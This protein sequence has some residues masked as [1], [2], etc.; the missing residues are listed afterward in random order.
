MKKYLIP[1]LVICAL[2]A[3]AQTTP[4]KALIDSRGTL[5]QLPVGCSLGQLF[6]ATDA[7]AGANVYGCTTPGN[8]GVWTIQGGSGSGTVTA[9][10]GQAPITSSG[11]TAPQV[12][13]LGCVADVDA[14]ST[15]AVPIAGSAAATTAAINAC[16]AA[17]TSSHIYFPTG[18]YNVDNSAN[19]PGISS[20]TFSG[21]LDF[22][23]GALIKFNTISTASGDVLDLENGTNLT[24]RNIHITGPTTTPQSRSNAA[25]ALSNLGLHL[26]NQTNAYIDGA[27]VDVSGGVCITVELSVHTNLSNINMANCS[28][29]GLFIKSADFTTLTNFQSNV[30]FDNPIELTNYTVDTAHV[31]TFTGSNIVINNS[32]ALGIAVPGASHVTIDGFVVNGTCSAGIGVFTD[33]SV[34]TAMPTD[35]HFSHGTITGAGTYTN[36]ISPCTS[37][38]GQ[39]MNADTFGYASFSDITVTG[40]TLLAAFIHIGTNAVLNNITAYSNVGGVVLQSVTAVQSTNVLL[41]GGTGNYFATGVTTLTIDGYTAHNLNPSNGL[42]RALDLESNG[43]VSASNINIEDTQATPTGYIF[44]GIGSTNVSPVSNLQFNVPHGSGTTSVDGTFNV[45][46]AGATTAL[47]ATQVGY[48]NSGSTSITSDSG[49]K[50]L[51]A[52]TTSSAPV[53]VTKSGTTGSSTCGYALTGFNNI[54]WTPLS[55]YVSVT[56]CNIAGINNAI[57]LPSDAGILSYCLYVQATGIGIPGLIACQLVPGSTYHDTTYSGQAVAFPT[58]N[59][60]TTT[61]Q[62]TNGGVSGT[63]GYIGNI[64]GVIPPSLASS[65]EQAPG[66]ILEIDNVSDGVNFNN[67]LFIQNVLSGVPSVAFGI[68]TVMYT[69]EPTG[70]SNTNIFGVAGSAVWDGP[71]QAGNVSSANNQTIIKQ[72]NVGVATGALNVAVIQGGT[73]GNVYG[74]DSGITML[75]GTATNIIGQLSV[76]EIDASAAGSVTGYITAGEF[77]INPNPGVTPNSYNIYINNTGFSGAGTTV[78]E[79][80]R[81]ENGA[82]SGTGSLGIHVADP[83]LDNL[84]EGTLHAGPRT[85]FTT[86]IQTELGLSSNA[87]TLLNNASHPNTLRVVN[88]ENGSN[89]NA[90]PLSS[91]QSCSGTMNACN[92]IEGTLDVTGGTTTA[93]TG[94]GEQV[95]VSGGVVSAAYGFLHYPMTITGGTVTLGYG[96]LFSA[97]AI[98][99]G[100]VLTAYVPFEANGRPAGSDTSFIVD[101]NLNVAPTSRTTAGITNSFKN[102][103]EGATF[104]TVAHNADWGSLV[105]PT[106]NAG[107]STWHLQSRIDSATF[108][109]RLTVSDT[110]DTSTPG[111]LISGLGGS[112]AGDLE[113]S[114]GTAPTPGASVFGWVAPTAMTTSVLLQSPNAVPAANQVMLF[115]APAS[116]IAA[117]TWVSIPVTRG[118]SDL[119]A[120]TA[121]LTSSALFT[122]STTGMYRVTYYAKITTPGTSS[123]LGG[124]TGFVLNYTD[125]TDSVAQNLTLTEAN[126][127]GTILSI[128]TGNVTNTTAAVIYGTATVFAK[129]GVAMTYNLGYSSTGTVMQYEVHVKAE[130]L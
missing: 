105:I 129:T 8:P 70:S 36:A 87:V 7:I 76:V 83:A 12:R 71:G 2:G 69:T 25:A 54:G 88:Q 67:T 17:H 94:S 114:A 91:H 50:R 14:V 9:V 13:C 130:A 19:Q 100:G 39:G 110:G 123:I 77:D 103:V 44:L 104:D 72:G 79:G 24:I 65:V 11:G 26:K 18:V 95:N 106:S 68:S 93:G 64:Q 57:V 63:H 60:N 61:G 66:N 85:G 62:L 82:V 97:P 3:V 99:G 59:A 108:T 32:T 28:S 98:S 75:N 119:T 23:P 47:P 120:Q 27:Q 73:L 89:A 33:S 30:T 74:T 42:H 5:A 109:D 45:I 16:L 122:P 101:S 1:L 92:G 53:S 58:P 15:C 41:S 56:N 118:A 84:F 125:G 55:S 40:S 6:F 96:A 37:P 116:N 90:V 115:G 35:V 81:I 4:P 127:S 80:L 22:A 49:F 102:I 10:T 111:S 31:G 46:I 128:G 121:A 86:A 113:L 52:N 126:Q 29:N 38:V 112:V 34:G 51:V 21:T 124:T 43:W 20:S 78:N 117:F 107:V 48:G